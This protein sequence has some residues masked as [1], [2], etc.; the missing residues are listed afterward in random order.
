MCFEATRNNSQSDNFMGLEEGKDMLHVI[1]VQGLETGRHFG[2]IVG[3]C[4]GAIGVWLG[5][6]KK[7][8]RLF[9]RQRR[10]RHPPAISN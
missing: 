2:S 7:C 10:L 5:A 8:R 6:G 4:P 1:T 9:G 3:R